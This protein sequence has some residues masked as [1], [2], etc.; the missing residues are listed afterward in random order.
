L[1]V[2]VQNRKKIEDSFLLGY[3]D[4]ASLGSW[5]TL[6]ARDILPSAVWTLRALDNEGNGK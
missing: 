2:I 5:F 4:A 6:F 1:F 3:D